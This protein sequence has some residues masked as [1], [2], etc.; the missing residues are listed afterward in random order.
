MPTADP[1]IAQHHL[2][3]FYERDEDL[4]ATIAGFIEEGLDRREQI[5]LLATGAHWLR[6]RDLLTARARRALGSGRIV[7]ED[8]DD[9]LHRVT[10]DGTADPKR[11]RA[12]VGAALARVERPVRIF[13][14]V[15]GLIAGRGEI[16]AAVRI[17]QLAQQLAHDWGAQVLC[18]YHRQHSGQHRDGVERIVTCHD[19]AIDP[20]PATARPVLL[21]AD[22]F[23]D[24][25]DLY[26]AYL[27]LKGY[28][29][30]TAG[31]GVE[32]VERARAARPA[33][34]LLDVRMPRMSGLE[35]LRVLKAEPALGAVPIVALTAHALE[36]ERQ[37]F[38]AE[39][40]AAVITKPCLPE[41]LLQIVRQL[42]HA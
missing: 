12:I 6:V 32:A 35:A 27:E 18:A 24:G 33:L 4:C 34:I 8:A 42:V 26:T 40:F 28:T 30:V 31:D 21:L 23:E 39:G 10:C 19:G 2:V 1:G 9:I 37:A 14:E 16:A 41:D 11:F 36:T 15:A 7:V 3:C 22:D 25:R 38:L 29:V 20:I 5:V 17:E 13:G